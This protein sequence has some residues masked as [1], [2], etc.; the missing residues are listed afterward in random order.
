MQVSDEE[1]QAAC[2][3][4]SFVLAE[5][6]ER[7]LMDASSFARF[8]EATHEDLVKKRQSERF[9]QRL[10]EVRKRAHLQPF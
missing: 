7:I 6:D 8:K 2:A 1:V 4:V 9:V 10:A 5:P 3:K